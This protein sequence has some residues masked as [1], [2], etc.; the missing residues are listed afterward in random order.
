[1]DEEESGLLLLPEE[2]TWEK[3]WSATES[4]T[5]QFRPRARHLLQTLKTVRGKNCRQIIIGSITSSLF[6]V[7]FMLVVI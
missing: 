4:S 7:W 5:P 3:S 1:M 2:M 6:T